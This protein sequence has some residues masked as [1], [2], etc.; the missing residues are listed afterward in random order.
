MIKTLCDKFP[1]AVMQARRDFAIVK[2]TRLYDPPYWFQDTES[3]KEFKGLY[4]CIGWPGHVKDINDQPPGYA[5][6]IGIQKEDEKFRILDECDSFSPEQLIEKCLIM[7]QRW[8]FKLH[9]ALFEVFVGD[10][11]RFELVVAQFNSKMIA[12]SKSDSDAFMVSPPDDFEN[13]KR[14]DLYFRRLQ[15]VTSPDNKR[16]IIGNA[17]FLRNQLAAFK[18]DNPAVLAIGGLIHTLLGRTPWK[19]STEES[20]FEMPEL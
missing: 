9:P 17:S 20:V 15:Y 1:E 4:G 3:G 6:V 5:A 10:H 8:G 7:R 12:D 16:L 11:L 19:V 18:R 14:F 13:P 2:K